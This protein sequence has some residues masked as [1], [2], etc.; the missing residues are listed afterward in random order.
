MKI[1]LCLFCFFLIVLI[2]NDDAIAQNQGNITYGDGT[3]VKE[4]EVVIDGSPYFN[5]E[6]ETGLVKLADG[7]TFKDMMLKYNVY[8]DVLY[9]QD[10]NGDTKI[11]SSPVSEFK[12]TDVV[13]NIP[14]EL[15]FKNGYKDIPG[16]NDQSFFE[17]LSEGTVQLLKKDHRFVIESTGIDLGTTSKKFNDKES[18]YLIISGKVSVIK[19]DKKT[20]LALLSNKQTELES[21]IKEK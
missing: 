13:D 16:Y 21:Y 20:I 4:T 18:Y 9:F 15:D 7:R 11:F 12:I 19:K 6:W 14:H 2:N 8:K 10:G 17:V 5:N 3:L 1:K